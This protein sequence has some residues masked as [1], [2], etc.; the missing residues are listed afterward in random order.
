MSKYHIIGNH[1]SQLICYMFE[2]YLVFCNLVVPVVQLLTNA[3]RIPAYT[4]IVYHIKITTDH[5][6]V[7]LGTLATI[8]KL[9]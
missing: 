5:A 3:Y 7:I 4:E 1:M 8:V 2:T 6:A 9:I